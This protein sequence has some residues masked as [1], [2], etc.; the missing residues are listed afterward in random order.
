[1]TLML[2]WHLDKFVLRVSRLRERPGASDFQV[3]NVRTRLNNHPGIAE[4]ESAFVEREEYRRDLITVV[5]NRKHWLA[6]RP[7]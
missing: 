6:S 5:D 4:E 3:R 7:R 1:M 2:T